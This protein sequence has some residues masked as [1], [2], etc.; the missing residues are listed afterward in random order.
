MDRTVDWTALSTRDTIS[1][2]AVSMISGCTIVSTIGV[3]FGMTLLGW[4]ARAAVE[5]G[6]AA[7][8]S[9]GCGDNSG[10]VGT[11]S[12]LR[13]RHTR[14]NNAASKMTSNE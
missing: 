2:T 5:T 3:G 8:S 6:R 12:E 9:D 4:D 13:V 7:V 14:T 11:V 1:W 10:T